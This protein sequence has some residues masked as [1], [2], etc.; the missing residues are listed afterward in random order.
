MAASMSRRCPYGNENHLS[1]RHRKSPVGG[2]MQ[3]SH[4]VIIRYQRI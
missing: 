3:S 2:D 1:I 4:F